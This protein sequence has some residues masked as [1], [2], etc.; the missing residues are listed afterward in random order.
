LLHCCCFSLPFDGGRTQQ[1]L[2]IHLKTDAKIA[3]EGMW[4]GGER[5]CCQK[6]T[7]ALIL[8]LKFNK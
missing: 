1:T 4:E 6:A 7:K 2:L 3:A 8:F 5:N